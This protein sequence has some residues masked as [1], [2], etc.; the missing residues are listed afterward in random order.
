MRVDANFYGSVPMSD[1]G[2]GPP[3]PVERRCG[4]A[5][6]LACYDNLLHWARTMDRLGYDTMWL[7]EHHFQHEGYEVTPNLILFGL[8]LA[9]ETERLR[10]GQMFNI[11]PQ[12]HPLRLAEDAATMQILT[13]DRMQF[14]VGRGTVPREAQ[15]LGGVVASGDNDMSAD[16]DRINREIFEESMEIITTAWNQERFSFSG[17]HFVLPPPGIPDRGS[18]VQ[19][20]TLVPRP[21]APIDVWQAVTSPPTL[22]YCARVGHHAVIP[23]R[24]PEATKRWWDEFADRSAAHGRELGPGERRCLAINVHVGR[25]HDTAV[26]TGRDPHDEWVKFL[27]PY[28][29]FRG[30][31]MADGSDT[32]FDHRPSIEDSIEQRVMAIGSV[33]EVAETLAAYRDEVGCQHLVMFFDMPGLTREQM[34]EQLELTAHEVL[35]QLG[36]PP[37]G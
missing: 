3:A 30:Y 29:R 6:V 10:L 4:N 2:W 26:R 25:T 33:D 11:V 20:L 27:S 13:G 21:I 35:P 15:S 9:K 28:G 36:V 12:W 14:G 37:P 23:A 8:H 5:D 1:A 31:R 22:E 24:G 19:E 34:D 17:K 7:T 32:P 16:L 18:T